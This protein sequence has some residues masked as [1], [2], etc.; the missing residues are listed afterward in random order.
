[1]KEALIDP[2]VIAEWS[3]LKDREP[4]HAKV[5]KTDLVIVRFDDDVGINTPAPGAALDVFG[6]NTGDIRIGDV[7]YRWCNGND[8]RRKLGNHDD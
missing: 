1:M 7:V 5:E 4:A 2:V 8:Y 3:D 6:V